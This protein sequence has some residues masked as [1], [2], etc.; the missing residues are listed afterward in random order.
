MI[1][2]CI[3]NKIDDDLEAEVRLAKGT[4]INEKTGEICSKSHTEYS[5]VAEWKVSLGRGKIPTKSCKVT[6]VVEKMLER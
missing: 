2:K 3:R 1:V 4:R 5:G 6:V